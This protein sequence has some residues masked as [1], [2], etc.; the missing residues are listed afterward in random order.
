MSLS[1]I[2]TPIFTSTLYCALLTV[3]LTAWCGS[4][5]ASDILEL[6]DYH[7]S[8]AKTESK[9][10]WLGLQQASKG[11]RL[12][13]VKP[14]FKKIPDPLDKSGVRV[15]ANIS[16]TRMILSDPGLKAGAVTL[17]DEAKVV[18]GSIDEEFELSTLP[19]LGQERLMHLHG[20]EYHLQ[21]REGRIYLELNGVAQYLFDYTENKE[22]NN[23]KII[24][25]GDLDHDGKL[26][27]I[28]DASSQYNVTELRL[29]LSGGAAKGELLKLVAQRKATGC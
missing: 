27:F 6:Q 29:Y 12:V 19:P 25:V 9:G 24:W 17:S 11:W 16:N 7:A 20:D 3:S 13:A 18:N 14:Q 8:E 21:N 1:R 23:A 28:F 2:S 22:D 5:A 4:A 26:D 10:P 15:S